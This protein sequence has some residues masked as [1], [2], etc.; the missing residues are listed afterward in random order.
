MKYIIIHTQYACVHD[1]NATNNHQ[2]SNGL[3][4]I[5]VSY[6]SCLVV[7]SFPIVSFYIRF[8]TEQ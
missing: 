8:I 7:I 4:C 3:L 2:Q 6:V 1:N 5:C